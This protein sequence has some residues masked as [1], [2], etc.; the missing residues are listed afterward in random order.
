[1]TRRTGRRTVSD[2]HHLRIL[3]LVGFVDKNVAQV[4]FDLAED[5]RDP[6]IYLVQPLGGEAA[7][8]VKQSGDVIAIPLAKADHRRHV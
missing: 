5:P 4:T 7:L 1:M 6:G 3:D 8:V 2:D